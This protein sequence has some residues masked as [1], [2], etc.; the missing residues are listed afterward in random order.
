VTKK[1]TTRK[2]KEQIRRGRG[3]T[4]TLTLTAEDVAAATWVA[5][6]LSTTDATTL[7]RLGISTLIQSLTAADT[8]PASTTEPAAGATNGH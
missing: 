7:W 4:L 5:R 2:L 8:V 6:R 3:R 1:S